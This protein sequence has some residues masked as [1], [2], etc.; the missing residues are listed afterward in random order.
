MG[1]FSQFPNSNVSK[2]TVSDIEPPTPANGDVWID[3]SVV[4]TDEETVLG[5]WKMNELTGTVVADSGDNAYHAASNGTTIVNGLY[6]TTGKAQQGNGAGYILMP[7]GASLAGLG[8]FK[9]ELYFRKDAITGDGATRQILNQY[10]KT[11]G[12]SSGGFFFNTNA[13][14]QLQTNCMIGGVMKSIQPLPLLVPTVGVIYKA[15]LEYD[16]AIY[17]VTVY[18]VNATTGE[19]TVIGF[20]YAFATGAVGSDLKPMTVLASSAADHAEKGYFT[21]DGLRITTAA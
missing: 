20:N 16:G 19:L 12:W 2:I 21:V 18:T 3:T 13:S 15:V 4:A 8:K 10:I 5:Y 17:K 9:I 6:P 14:N 1:R 7:A 11:D